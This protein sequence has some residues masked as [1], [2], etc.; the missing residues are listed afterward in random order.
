MH[1]QS[2]WLGCSSASS[3]SSGGEIDLPHVLAALPRRDCRRWLI[4]EQDTIWR[5]PSESTA[6]SR[7]VVDFVLHELPR[8]Q[9]VA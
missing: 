2:L 7:A 3:P 1:E 4:V 8:M 5:L 6:I 9:L